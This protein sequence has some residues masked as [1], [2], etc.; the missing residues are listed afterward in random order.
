MSI[1]EPKERNISLRIPPNYSTWETIELTNQCAQHA[2]DY[3]IPGAFIECGVAAGNNLAAMCLAG[4]HG[5]GFDSFQGIPWAGE[6][7]AE[8]P[9]IGPKDESKSGILESSGITVHGIEQVRANMKKWGISNYTLHPGW[10]QDTVRHFKEPIAVLRLDGD[11]YEST[12]CCLESL[13]PLLADGGVLIVDD[14]QLPGCRKA[15]NEY[16]SSVPTPEMIFENGGPAY[17][18]KP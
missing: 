14:W 4:R 5:H 11:L 1:S 15:F 6:H 3:N 7:D 12:Q 16:F 9:G 17:F 8:Q 13:Y 2:I 10:F 18:L